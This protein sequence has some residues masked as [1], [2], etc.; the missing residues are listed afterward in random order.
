MSRFHFLADEEITAGLVNQAKTIRACCLDQKT[1]FQVLTVPANSLYIE[2]HRLDGL[3]RLF[4]S[5]GLSPR[6]YKASGS[7]DIQIYLSFSAQADTVELTAALTNLLLS[8]G[9]ELSNQTLVV[10]SRELPFVLPL[11]PGFAW[12]NNDFELKLKRDEIA[13]QA[14]MALFLDELKAAAVD[15]ALLLDFSVFEKQDGGLLADTSDDYVVQVEITEE[16]FTLES[17][18][19][20]DQG[21]TSQDPVLNLEFVAVINEAEEIAP[22]LQDEPSPCSEVV[23]ADNSKGM[24]LLLFPIST[25]EIDSELPQ[26]RKLRGRKARS[27]PSAMAEISLV[28]D[29][30]FPEDPTD[31]MSVPSREKEVANDQ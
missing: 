19:I 11:Q 22:E 21:E 30:V 2:K 14:A 13:L 29:K 9:Y 16:V 10:H 3:V 5:T 18:T 7:D 23:F 1:T 15:P 25:S 26:S 17:Q 31:H 28:S 4:L 6:L 12:L 8:A 20:P 27:D 24:Q